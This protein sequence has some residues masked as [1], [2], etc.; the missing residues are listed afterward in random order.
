M[1]QFMAGAVS[2]ALAVAGLFFLRFWR[3]T[4]DRLFILFALAFFAL[5]INR[6]GLMVVDV[7]GGHG[8]HLYWV[9]FLAFVV[10]FIA[11]WDKNRPPRAEP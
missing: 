5:A 7:Q 6:V 3:D 1:T 10:I 11:V 4:R 9:R 2:M 8:D